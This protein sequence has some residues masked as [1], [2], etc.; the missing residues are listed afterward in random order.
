VTESWTN[1]DGTKGFGSFNDNVEAYAPGS[2]IFA[3]SGND[4][5]TGAGGN[6]EF[7]IAQP[8]GNDVIYNFNAASDKIDLVGFSNV[9]KFGDIQLANDAN[10]NAV[11]TL[12]NAET[13][14]LHGTDAA[15]LTAANFLFDQTPVVENHASMVIGD[16]A[17]LPL[18]GTIDNTG[19]IALNASGDQTELQIV[20][21]GATLQGG[22]Q[23]VLSDS[24]ANVIVGTTSTTTLTN[25]DN[26]ISG[27][28]QI[29]LGDGNLTLV[30]DAHGTIDADKAGS[31]LIINTG[32]AVIDAGL[33]EA[34]NGGTLLIE[35]AVNGSGSGS[36]VIYGGTLEFGA[37]SNVNVTFNNGA[38][39]AAY[40]QLVLGDPANFCGQISGFTGT[41]PDAA[42]S[43]S[44]DLK[45]INYNSGHFSETYCAPTGL[46]TVT[47]G[48]QTIHLTFDG[49]DGTFSF[50]VTG[51]KMMLSGAGGV[52][53]ANC[54]VPFKAFRP[55]EFQ[56][57]QAL[58]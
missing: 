25:V 21:H 4:T 11:V 20:G 54:T 29:G 22:G 48:N 41:G 51:G 36:A 34:S 52:D 53:V 55:P 10:G 38:G 14:T 40:G 27:A 16:G 35:D 57:G 8:I 42:H 39:T 49:F 30:N 45:G 1:A 46:L 5:L 3:W 12:G 37:S 50:A 43:D 7:V 56:L 6:D 15:S 17:L 24:S 19:I 23:L 31:T 9:A 28:G 44:I 26:T 47:D 18:A 13:I 33:L 2:P 32:H 58:R